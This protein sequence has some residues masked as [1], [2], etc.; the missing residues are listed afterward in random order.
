MKKTRPADDMYLMKKAFPLSGRTHIMGILNVTPDSFSDGG[1]FF[2]PC[3]AVARAVEMVDQGAD[4]IDIGGESSRPGSLR[5]SGK[6]ELERLM[7]VVK[8][9]RKSLKVPLSVDTYKSEVAE[10]VLA[11][12]VDYIN[13]ITALNGDERMAEVVSSFGAGVILM[14]MKG[15]PGTMQQDPSYDDVISE[16]TAYLE[17]SIV[18]AEEAGIDPG[19]IFIDPGI[20]FGKKLGHNIQILRR[21]KEFEKLGKPLLVGTSRKSFIGEITGKNT[22]DRLFGTA[23]SIS[24]AIMNGADMVRVHD[25][26]EMSDVVKITDSIIRK[27]N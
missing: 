2:E 25:I 14:H 26:E 10:R 19:K 18:K 8:E 27:W 3:K 6:E 4:I 15:T 9:L 16:I 20:G 21:L 5:I 22:G 12:G 7:P 1:V 11:E 13:D 24:A 17:D 23:A